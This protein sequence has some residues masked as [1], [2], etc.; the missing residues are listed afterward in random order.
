MST[1]GEHETRARARPAFSCTCDRH[2]VFHRDSHFCPLYP[3][4]EVEG[5][6]PCLD[7][8]LDIPMLSLELNSFFSILFLQKGTRVRKERMGFREGEHSK[9]DLFS[10]GRQ[11][12]L[13]NHNS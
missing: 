5:S 12:W 11:R 6:I 7:A 10:L 8:E 4:A 9:T 1:E 13:L 2:R 3:C